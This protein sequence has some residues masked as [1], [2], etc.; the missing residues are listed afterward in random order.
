MHFCQDSQCFRRE[1]QSCFFTW[2]WFYS[3]LIT[4]K[5]SYPLPANYLVQ[6]TLLPS[7]FVTGICKTSM[8]VPVLRVFLDFSRHEIHGCFIPLFF[9]FSREKTPCQVAQILRSGK[10]RHTKIHFRKGACMCVH[11]NVQFI[12]KAKQKENSSRQD[13]DDALIASWQK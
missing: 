5:S 7:S 8:K 11:F 10:Q 6:R 13:D 2:F 4:L 3:V 12:P 9:F 1:F